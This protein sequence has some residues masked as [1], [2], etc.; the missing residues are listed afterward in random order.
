MNISI[1][2]ALWAI[3]VG[4]KLELD[5]PKLA[6]IIK[7]FDS[8]FREN[9]GPLSPILPLLPH[10]SMA[11]WPGLRQLIGVENAFAT[12]KATQEFIEPYITEHKR[13]LDPDNV[14]DFVDLMLIEIQNTTDKESSFYGETGKP[15]MEKRLLSIFKNSKDQSKFLSVAKTVLIL[16]QLFV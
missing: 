7:R 15:F 16:N 4:E 5:D 14:R 9:S 10:P 6:N 12:F 1:L 13:T 11:K 8:L 2:N 3:L